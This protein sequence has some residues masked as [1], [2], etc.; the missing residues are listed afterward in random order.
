MT[1]DV[2]IVGGGQAALSVAYFLRRTQRSFLMLDA[3]ESSGGAWQ[4]G[5]DSLR[6]FSPAAWSSIAG[7]P[8]PNAGTTYPGRDHVVSY[9][10]DYEKRYALQVERPVLVSS[11]T[12]VEQ[13]FEVQAD[14]QNWTARTIV[15]ATGT[16]RKP[17]VPAYPGMANFSGRQLHSAH[18]RSP[19]EFRGQRVMIVGG[20]NSGAQ[21]LAEVSLSAAETV[22][23]TQEEPRFLPDDVDGRVLFE[24]ATARWRA[25]QEGRSID[26]LPGGFGDIVMVPPVMDARARGVLSSVR[27]FEHMTSQGAV[28]SDG[29]SRNVDAVIW[30]TGFRAALDHLMPL[31]IVE[32]GKVAVEG[33]RSRDVPGLWLVGYGE[34]SGLAS[35]T[36]IG[37]MRTARSTASEVDAFLRT[38]DSAVRHT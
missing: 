12:R 3:E 30:C 21:I 4:H 10:R 35:A 17:F 9:L 1:H 27:P 8:M 5:W 25:H 18:Y 13:G 14:D 15:S 26:V 34:W 37:V 33:T 28:W 7:W 36:L 20:G 2:I 32:D 19:Y 16:W 38:V 6:L 24:R 22:W 29:A 31:G 23:V 11:V